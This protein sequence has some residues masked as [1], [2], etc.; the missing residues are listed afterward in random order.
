MCS[1][2]LYG[3]IRPTGFRVIVEIFMGLEY[4]LKEV[5]VDLATAARYSRGQLALRQ[6]K[7]KASPF[8]RQNMNYF[9]TFVWLCYGLWIVI[10]HLCTRKRDYTDLV[11]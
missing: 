2:L 3:K 6:F 1:D 11:I 5:L 9:S 10:H 7:G 8:D 4:E